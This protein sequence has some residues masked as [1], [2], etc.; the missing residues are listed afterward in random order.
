[1]RA[2]DFNVDDYVYKEFPSGGVWPAKVIKIEFDLV[3]TLWLD[4][5]TQIM[6]TEEL[7]RHNIKLCPLGSK[8]R[9][10]VI[11]AMK[12]VEKKHEL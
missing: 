5:S 10:M 4:G 3:T 9:E 1:M 6:K 12:D 11:L 7:N 2:S 8:I